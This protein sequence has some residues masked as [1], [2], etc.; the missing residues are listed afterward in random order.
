MQRDASQF[1]ALL[2][3]ITDVTD[4]S[5]YLTVYQETA[6]E[7]VRFNSLNQLLFLQ[8]YTIYSHS[9]EIHESPVDGQ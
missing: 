3:Q 5:L 6:S 1:C 8:S 2:G 9:Y 7:T 4:R